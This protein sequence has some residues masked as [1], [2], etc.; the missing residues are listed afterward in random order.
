M[1]EKMEIT[2]LKVA[3][4]DEVCDANTKKAQCSQ[5]L[6]FSALTGRLGT[7]QEQASV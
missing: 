2:A 3:E 1:Q 6:V 7:G 5:L 4:K